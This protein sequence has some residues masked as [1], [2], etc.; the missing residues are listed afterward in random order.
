VSAPGRAVGGL[1]VGGL[2]LGGLLLGG[3][4]VGGWWRI[5][6]GHVVDHR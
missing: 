6:V 5:A 2:L 4:V 1:L 3:R